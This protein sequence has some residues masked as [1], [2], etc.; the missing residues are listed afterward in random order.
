MF[1]VFDVRN[2]FWHVELD[3]ES[4]KLTT[5]ITPFGRYRWLRMPFGL[6][7]APEEFQRR[8]H[9][10]VEGLPGVMAIHD[11]ILVVGKGKTHKEA[12]LDH[13]RNVHALMI[14]CRE[15]NTD[16]NLIPKR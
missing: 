2:G 10:V 9:H 4:S 15:R 12:Q 14:R 11:D 8:Q 3:E 1:S 13:D 16:S 7:S 6:T 5:F